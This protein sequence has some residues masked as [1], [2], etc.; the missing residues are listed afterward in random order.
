MLNQRKVKK[1]ANMG[2][3][4]SLQEVKWFS[5]GQLEK[6]KGQADIKSCRS[7][8]SSVRLWQGPSG[9]LFP[10][11]VGLAMKLRSKSKWDLA[12]VSGCYLFQLQLHRSAYISIEPMKIES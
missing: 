6:K 8:L 11:A 4:H 9:V 10:E 2:P 7:K 12:D 3:T 1:N 5:Q